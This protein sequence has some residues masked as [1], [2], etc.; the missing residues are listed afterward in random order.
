MFHYIKKDLQYMLKNE[1][2]LL[3]FIFLVQLISVVV[4]FFSYG[5]INHYNTKVGVVEDRALSYEFQVVGNN[6]ITKDEVEGF[7]ESVIASMDVKFE[8]IYVMG[9]GGIMSDGGYNIEEKEYVVPTILINNVLYKYLDTDNT[10]FDTDVENVIQQF[11]S[12]KKVALVGSD[13][14]PEEDTIVLC[15][16]EYTIIGMFEEDSPYCDVIEIPFSKLPEKLEIA[17]IYISFTRPMLEP[18]YDVLSGAVNLYLGDKVEMPEFNGIKNENEYRVYRSIMLI[19][20]VFIFMC[21]VNCCIVYSHLLNKRRRMFS[22][23][24]ICGCTKI[25][26]AVIYLMELLFM[27]VVPLSIGMILFIKVVMPMSESMFEYMRYYLNTRVYIEIA[28]MY[29]VVLLITYLSL[30]VHFVKKTPVALIKEV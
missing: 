7:Y 18:E 3:L 19:L 11:E 29:L 23:S 15:D 14:L 20:A 27:S 12:D 5:V 4:V 16:E 26:A 1:K 28:L 22:V 13:I 8:R 21:G 24:R 9:K 17:Y 30:V 25:K 2:T 6:F 10:R